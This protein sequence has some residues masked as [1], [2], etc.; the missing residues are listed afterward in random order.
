MKEGNMLHARTLAICVGIVC[1]STHALGGQSVSK[2]RDFQLGSDLASVSTRAG[3]TPSDAKTIHAR[4]AVLQDLEWRLSHWTSGST[5]PSTDPV[6]QLLFSFYNDQLFRIVV[7]Y[8]HERTEGM[9]TADMA[10]AI[11]AVYGAPLVAA[12]NRESGSAQARWGD[13]EHAIVLYHTS[14]YGAEFRVVVTDVRLENL[15]RKAE[16]QA[17]RLDD[18]EAPQR[19]VA[20]QQKERA[21]A[22]AAAAKARAANKTMFRP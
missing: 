18:R 7:D 2:Y 11:S 5:A 16:A 21:A 12:R 22:N 14:S 17:Q 13:S 9:T 19:E 15:A 20:L 4:P 1:C 3:L 10:E 6:E 8:S